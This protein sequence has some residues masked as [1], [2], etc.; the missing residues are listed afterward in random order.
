MQNTN[1]RRLAFFGLDGRQFLGFVGRLKTLR[2]RRAKRF[3]TQ[4]KGTI[5]GRLQ[6]LSRLKQLAL[7][8]LELFS[9]NFNFRAMLLRLD[10]A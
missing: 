3:A 10:V 4:L 9:E 8:F 1:W 5:L 2:S 6:A 7:H